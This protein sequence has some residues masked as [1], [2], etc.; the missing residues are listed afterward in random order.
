MKFEKLTTIIL[1]LFVNIS[2][3]QLWGQ[4]MSL[5][6]FTDNEIIQ[7]KVWNEKFEV[8]RKINTFL[9]LTDF[10][11]QWDKKEQI[12]EDGIVNF[13]FKIDIK[14]GNSKSQRWLYNPRHGYAKVLTKAKS[15]L[16]KV[17]NPDEFAK[18]VLGDYLVDICV[19]FKKEHSIDTKSNY[20]YLEFLTDVLFVSSGIDSSKGKGYFYKTGE[21]WTISVL[22]N[23]VDEII[24]ILKENQT[25]LKSIDDIVCYQIEYNHKNR[26]KYFEI[27]IDN[28]L[29]NTTLFVDIIEKYSKINQNFSDKHNMLLTKIYILLLKNRELNHINRIYKNLSLEMRYH[30]LETLLIK[31]KIYYQGIQ[32]PFNLY[33]KEQRQQFIFDCV[34]NIILFDSS[35]KQAYFKLLELIIKDNRYFFSPTNFIRFKEN[36]IESIKENV[37]DIDKK[38]IE[39]LEELFK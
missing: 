20:L 12:I 1:I 10:Q 7:V 17:K 39:V 15:P 3:A 5:K 21:K 19:V 37:W 26:L 34:E 25:K 13:D 11:I 4:D 29:I 33:G 30:F 28:E 18:T 27:L 16:Y 2:M 31:L 24:N 32:D 6:E 8:V 9:E 22:K 38:D 36:M 14:T 35:E 23:K